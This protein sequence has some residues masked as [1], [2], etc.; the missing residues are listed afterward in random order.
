MKI[1]QTADDTTYHKKFQI[2]NR[3][4]STRHKFRLESGLNLNEMP[5]SGISLAEPTDL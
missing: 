4:L 1:S 5:L 3:L 2:S